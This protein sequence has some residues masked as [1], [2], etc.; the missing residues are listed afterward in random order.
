MSWNA[1]DCIWGRIA[2]FHG[3]DKPSFHAASSNP[4]EQLGLYMKKDDEE[5]ED[6]EPPQSVSELVKDVD[7]GQIDW[8]V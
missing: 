8:R 3:G 1:K 5:D 2:K 4:L 6:N 7:E